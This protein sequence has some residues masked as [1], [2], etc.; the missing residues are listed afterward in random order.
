MIKLAKNPL[1]ELTD[2]IVR[3]MA[4][5]VGK[6]SSVE[7]ETITRILNEVFPEEFEP[8]KPKDVLL[9]LADAQTKALLHDLAGLKPKSAKKITSGS[10][11]KTPHIKWRALS[12]S[13]VSAPRSCGRWSAGSF[14]SAC[15][16]LSSTHNK[17]RWA[18][19]D[20]G[21]EHLGSC[22]EVASCF[23]SAPA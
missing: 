5:I 15:L 1:S 18:Y 21:A 22:P 12:I 16:E 7:L 20:T 8:A 17:S 13:S 2:D 11:A 3:M 23:E 4:P 14:L 9:L 10:S 19:D 6:R